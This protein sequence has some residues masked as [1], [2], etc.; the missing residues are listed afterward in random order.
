VDQFG[1]LITC[2]LI[3]FLKSREDSDVEFVKFHGFTIRASRAASN[4]AISQ[5]GLPP[6]ISKDLTDPGPGDPA[7]SH[8]R[9]YA[10]DLDDENPQIS[11]KYEEFDHPA[12]LDCELL[13]REM[14]RFAELI[15]ARFAWVRR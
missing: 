4:F 7:I 13:A 3:V 9:P 5:H 14:G 15:G 11:P 6:P 12:R 1:Q 10:H 8:R 2:P